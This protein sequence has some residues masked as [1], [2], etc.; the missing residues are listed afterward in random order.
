MRWVLFFI[1]IKAVQNAMGERGYDHGRYS[2]KSQSGKQSMTGSKYFGGGR[3]K[4]IHGSHFA[5]NH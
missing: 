1:E 4:K 3:M 5:Q 2:D